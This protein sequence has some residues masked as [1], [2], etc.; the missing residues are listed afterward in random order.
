MPWITV[1]KNGLEVRVQKPQLDNMFRKGFSI[2][3]QSKPAAKAKK[4]EVKK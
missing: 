3:G 2:K 1:E 4:K